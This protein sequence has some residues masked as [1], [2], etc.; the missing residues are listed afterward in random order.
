MPASDTTVSMI[1]HLK[2]AALST[3]FTACVLYDYFMRKHRASPS[4]LMLCRT[5]S[6]QCQAL[7][8]LCTA[9]SHEDSLSVSPT[10]TSCHTLAA[11]F[12]ICY[13]ISGLYYVI[14]CFDLYFTLKNPFRRPVSNTNWIHVVVLVIACVVTIPIAVLK[15]FTFREDLQFCWIPYDSDSMFWNLFIVYVPQCTM[16]LGG[17]A[18]TY[19]TLKGLQDTI[20]DT[21]FELRW[22]II[23]RQTSIV[24]CF[25]CDWVIRGRYTFNGLIHPFVFSSN[26]DSFS[27]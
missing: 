26:S 24:A 11:V 17:I 16:V 27:I 1:S 25:T 21:T 4:K 8:F 23:K 2:Y 19:F 18:V 3:F 6:D 7:I 10:S 20:L 9:R 22:N 14:I 12:T 13:I 15:S 5:L